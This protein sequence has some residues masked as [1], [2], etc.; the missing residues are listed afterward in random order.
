MS[1]REMISTG[2]GLR[3]FWAL[4]IF[5]CLV[6]FMLFVNQGCAGK[7]PT[8]STMVATATPTLAP[9]I[10]ANL[11]TGDLKLNSTT[12]PEGVWYAST[13]GDPGNKINANYVTCG[14]VGANGTS[15]AIHLFGAL[16][17]N[18]DGQYPS[19]QLECI[20]SNGYFDASAFT[21][22]RFYYNIASDD[23]TVPSDSSLGEVSG[24]PYRRF[25][26]VIAATQE[27]IKGG[28]CPSDCY[29]HFGVALA[30]TAGSWSE[31]SCVF[32]DLRKSFDAYPHSLTVLNTDVLKQVIELQWQVGRNGSKGRYNVDYWVDEVSFF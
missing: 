7:G 6:G 32:S 4:A 31:K 9:N 12:F 23:Q 1:L 17:D 5:A 28:L 29:D 8:Q 13:W 18:A 21:G 10:V 20:L 22:V 2:N 11:E 3:S 14:G 25:N 30:P 27:D 24:T 26:L 19:F 16:K 15:C